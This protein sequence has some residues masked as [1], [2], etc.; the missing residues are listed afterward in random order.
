M[1][2]YAKTLPGSVYVVERRQADAVMKARA[3]TQMPMP[4]SGNEA[5]VDAHPPDPTSS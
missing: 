3:A 2:T 4:G 1:K 5:A